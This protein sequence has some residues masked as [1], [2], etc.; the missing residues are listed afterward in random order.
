MG[1]V[2]II[3]IVNWLWVIGDRPIVDPATSPRSRSVLVALRQSVSESIS[4]MAQA[5]RLCCQ[6]ATT[7]GSLLREPGPRS[8]DSL[9][10]ITAKIVAENIP[11]QRIEERYDRIPEPVQRRIIYWSFPRN[12]R[13]I[14]MYSSLS[15]V[16]PV[17]ASGEP[18]NL[19]FCKGLK[20]LE[21]GCVD[22]VLQVGKFRWDDSRVISLPSFPTQ[23]PTNHLLFTPVLRKIKLGRCVNSDLGDKYKYVLTAVCK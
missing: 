4:S 15:R 6:R 7:N 23:N 2:G 5:R 12:E 21:T 14:C 3:K 13:D 8:P 9:L 22:N 18:Q 17:N 16:P 10:D 11:F 20:L 1:V 19:S